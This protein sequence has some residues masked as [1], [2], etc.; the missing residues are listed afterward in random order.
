M[1]VSLAGWQG[2]GKDCR[3][4]QQDEF[5]PGGAEP[6]SH[7]QKGGGEHSLLSWWPGLGR[8]T[9]RHKDKVGV[10]YLGLGSGTFLY[11][12]YEL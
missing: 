12:Q 6:S 4:G 5:K 7:R 1:R 2:A 11:P 10:L 9:S 3:W 8:G